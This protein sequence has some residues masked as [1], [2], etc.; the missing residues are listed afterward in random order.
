MYLYVVEE[1]YEISQYHKIISTQNSLNVQPASVEL[2]GVIIVVVVLAI[3]R[4]SRC[5]F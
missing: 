3:L 2:L 4:N 5:L 1:Y